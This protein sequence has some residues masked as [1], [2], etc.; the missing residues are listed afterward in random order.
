MNQQT[1]CH[2]CKHTITEHGYKC[3]DCSNFLRKETLY[4]QRCFEVIEHEKL[5]H[6]TIPID[7]T[8]GIDVQSMAFKNSESIVSEYSQIYNSLIDLIDM[9]N[10]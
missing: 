9:L 10:S 7:N 8:H 3:V 1:S 4:C 6:N 2:E 5:E